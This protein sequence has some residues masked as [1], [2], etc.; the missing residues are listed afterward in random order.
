MECFQ[1][2]GNFPRLRD[3][4]N[5]EAIDGAASSANVLSIQAEMA[6]GPVAEWGLI[7]RRRQITSAGR[8]VI[9]RLGG[10]ATGMVGS[11]YIGRMDSLGVKAGRKKKKKS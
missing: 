2:L 9:S 10:R 7:L 5:K 3:R 4:L 8:G 6:S 1:S 11:T